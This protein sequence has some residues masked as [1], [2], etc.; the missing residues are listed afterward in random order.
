MANTSSRRD[1]LEGHDG[2]DAIRNFVLVAGAGTAPLLLTDLIRFA[3]HRATILS[4]PDSSDSFPLPLRAEAPDVTGSPYRASRRKGGG[5]GRSS[6]GEP[7]RPER[8][9]S[10]VRR[11]VSMYEPG[12]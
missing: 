11:E 9:R 8:S 7:R 2:L 10:Y 5:H 6:V 12:G 3:G 1:S 4:P